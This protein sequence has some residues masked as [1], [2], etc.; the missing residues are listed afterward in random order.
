MKARFFAESGTVLKVS[1]FRRFQEELGAT[2]PTEIVIIDGLDPGWVT[3]MQYSNYAWR[4][5]PDSW[6]QR[7][8]LARFNLN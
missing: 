4:D 1:Y 5:I 8:Y 2:R 6:M 7:D 3:V